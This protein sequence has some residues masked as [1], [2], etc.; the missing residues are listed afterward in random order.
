MGVTKSSKE[1]GEKA[2]YK[3][4]V[5]ERPDLRDSYKKALVSGWQKP[6][7]VVGLP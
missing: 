2:T 4:G 6:K 7:G 5:G 3:G 1:E